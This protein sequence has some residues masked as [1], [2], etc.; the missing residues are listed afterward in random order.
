MTSLC[1]VRQLAA[2]LGL[3]VRMVRRYLASTAVEPTEWRGNVA[4]Y[5]TAAVQA[6]EAAVSDARAARIARVREAA[7]ERSAIV[8][9]ARRRRR[10]RADGVVSMETLN[11][12]AGR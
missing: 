2:G 5:D 8:A 3:S 7:A 10:P 1:T 9:S 12:E 4:L 6:V 11:R